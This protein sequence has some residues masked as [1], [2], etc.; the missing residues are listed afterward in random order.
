MKTYQIPSLKLTFDED[1]I[2]RVEVSPDIT[3]DIN[4]ALET[5]KLRLE[6]DSK[7]KHKII[8]TLDGAVNSTKAARD[9][10]ASETVGAFT[11]ANA[12]ITSSSITQVSLNFFL[13]IARPSFPVKF[14]T[15]KEEALTWLNTF[16]TE[17]IDPKDYHLFL[18]STY[19][20]L[21]KKSEN[22]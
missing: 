13:R 18:S 10:S 21:K 20:L 17:L 4:D 12:V 11:T 7:N 1:H 22:N 3:Y 9:F 14:F 5:L 19:P 15:S 16:K 8:S 6:A 2:M